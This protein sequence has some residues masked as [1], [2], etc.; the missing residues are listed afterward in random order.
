MRGGYFV[1]IKLSPNRLTFLL[2]NEL[3]HGSNAAYLRKYYVQGSVDW[4]QLLCTYLNRVESFENVLSWN[5]AFAKP[6]S[7]MYNAQ[8]KKSMFDFEKIIVGDQRGLHMHL[9][10]KAVSQ[11]IKWT[12]LSQARP[13]PLSI[14][15]LEYSSCAF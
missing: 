5:V 14:L 12:I 1:S 4:L 3:F 15:D 11:A 13:G 2:E 7:L 8:I 10:H 9:R 6:K